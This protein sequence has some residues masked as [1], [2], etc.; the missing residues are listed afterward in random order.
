MTYEEHQKLQRHMSVSGNLLLS[1]YDDVGTEVTQLQR[2]A[3]DPGMIDTMEEES[4]VF[5]DANHNPSIKKQY[6]IVEGTKQR[7]S[8]ETLTTYL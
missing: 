4:K 6:L 5:K 1:G 7:R 2:S 3:S 8:S